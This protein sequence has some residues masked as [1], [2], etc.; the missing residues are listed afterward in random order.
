MPFYIAHIT[1]FHYIQRRNKTILPDMKVVH[2]QMMTF[3]IFYFNGHSEN[4]I[5]LPDRKGEPR[6]LI[7]SC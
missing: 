1:L 3:N 2:D 7:L 6:A 4:L 5:L